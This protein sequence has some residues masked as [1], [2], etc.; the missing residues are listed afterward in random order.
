MGERIRSA[1]SRPRVSPPWPQ[2]RVPAVRR[3]RLLAALEP[4]VDQSGL[5][6]ALLSAPAGFGKTTLLSQFCQE[7]TDSGRG[8]VAW[9]ALET[10][11]KLAGSVWQ[12]ILSA[13]ESSPTR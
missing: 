8:H 9:V 11:G 13:L 4:L 5:P 10:S 2:L 1:P 6:V 12:T 7:V 3:D